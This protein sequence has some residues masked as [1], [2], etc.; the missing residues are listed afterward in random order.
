MVYGV[1]LRMRRLFGPSLRERVL[2]AAID[3]TLLSG[4]S[5]WLLDLP[6][7][8]AQISRAGVG[9]VLCHPRACAVLDSVSDGDSLIRIV[10]LSSGA[11]E[12]GAARKRLTFS[13]ESALSFGAD[14]IAFQINVGSSFELKSIRDAAYVCERAHRLGLPVQVIAYP[15]SDLADPDRNYLGLKKAD[16]IAY[17]KL[18]IRAVGVGLEVGADLI[19]TCYHDISLKDVVKYASPV[20]VVV[21]GGPVDGSTDLSDIARDVCDASAGGLAVGRGLFESERPSVVA[22]RLLSI[23]RA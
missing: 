22:E 8:L 20:P 23:M 4:P 3:D 17:S 19:K 16:P 2:I 7:Y 5:G 21:A 15:R 18:L 12:D 13:V 14:M 9:A 1:S 11:T 6:S 10:N